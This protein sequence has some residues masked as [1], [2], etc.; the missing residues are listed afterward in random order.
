[1]DIEAAAF[2]QGDFDRPAHGRKMGP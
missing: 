2:R 1:M